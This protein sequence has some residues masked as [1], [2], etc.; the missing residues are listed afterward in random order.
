[1]ETNISPNQPFFCEAP[2]YFDFTPAQLAQVSVAV[3]VGARNTLLPGLKELREAKY[4]LLVKAGVTNTPGYRKPLPALNAPMP[5]PVE[6]PM[7]PKDYASADELYFTGQRI[8][9]LCSPSFE[10][11]PYYEEILHRD[12]GD[13]RANTALGIL[14]CKQ[15]R[16][17]EAAKSLGN[18]TA[19]ATANYIRPKDGEAFYYLGLALRGE[20][21]FAGRQSSSGREHWLAKL[22]AAAD[23]FK[24]ASWSAAW[25]APS[26][27][28]LAEIEC[29]RGDFAEALT[30]IDQGLAQGRRNTKAMNL[31]SAILRHLGRFEEASAC[32]SEALSIDPLDSWSLVE[33][34]LA[35]KAVQKS[36]PPPFGF[37]SN[38]PPALLTKRVPNWLELLVDYANAGFK[39]EAANVVWCVA[40]DSDET[41]RMR[42]VDPIL[43]F[44]A[45]Y[46]SPSWGYYWDPWTRK[47][48]SN[49]LDSAGFK[50][51]RLDR[52][53]FQYE[54]IE[55]LND[56][57]NTGGA[58]VASYFLGNLLYD[59][60]PGQAIKNW[61]KARERFASTPPLRSKERQFLEA[62]VH[63]NLALAYAQHEKNVPK[64]IGSLE[65]AVEL[66][67]KEPRFF[68]ELD[69]QY[70]A[71]GAPVAQRLGLLLKYHDAVAQRDDALTREI[72]LLTVA[73]VQ[74][75]AKLGRA[76]G[77]LTAHRFHNWEGRSELH[78]V[79]A[80]AFLQR[81]HARLLAWNFQ[82]AL[83]D[84]YAALEYPA[85]LEVGR[86]RADR[87]EPEIRYA[88]GVAFDAM[89]QVQQARGEFERVAAWTESAR[90]GREAGPS[91]ILYFQGRALQKLGREAEAKPLFEKLLAHGETQLTKGEAADYFAKFGEKQSER[92]RKA[93][94][95]YLT[96]LGQL[97]LG[98][99]AKADAE[100]KQ[101]LE[102]HP[103]HL[104]AAMQR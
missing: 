20:A 53:P 80:D 52:L 93:N 9:Q 22:A 66:D 50:M 34:S 29:H 98:D 47:G 30:A 60:Q 26:L 32:A 104:G 75:T 2:L 12:P 61:E 57:A 35:A 19:R 59:N 3:K 23:A 54:S 46:L 102:L 77:F 97:G 17:A 7:P 38:I 33:H 87:K 73:G 55:V 84:Y 36:F 18:A 45:S 81:G 74:D 16:W 89:G 1:M 40:N 27:F 103:A 28:Q 13:Y 51:D 63:R 92:V 68:Y 65:K 71:G 43:H 78:G 86:P 88:L 41:L 6:R 72:V 5:K 83:D 85:N 31:R 101:A 48:G 70:E 39:S 58:E 56:A 91:E 100:F 82:G 95:H 99:K 67:P 25:Q 10:A 76:I 14:L 11:A 94:A 37:S 96:G 69:V 15:W 79:Y 21:G 4:E 49:A 90:K 64:A 42:P 44:W 24:K 62:L 8:E